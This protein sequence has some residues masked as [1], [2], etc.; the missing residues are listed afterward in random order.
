MKHSEVHAQL[1]DYL[2]GDLPIARRALVDAHI[3]ECPACEVRLS[4]LRATVDLLRSLGDPEPPPGLANAV[5]VRL[6]AGE[7]QPS[8]LATLL[9][10]I[11]RPIRA[12]LA[13]PM[14]V[15]AS[16]AVVFLW[17]RP[18][19]EASPPVVPSLEQDLRRSPLVGSPTAP[20]TPQAA[21]AL[22]AGP[23]VAPEDLDRALRDPASLV[24]AT[25]AL[26]GAQRDAWLAALAQQAGSRERVQALAQALRGLPDPNA[27]A[28]ADAL[29]RVRPGP[30]SR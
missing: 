26:N 18:G 27:A 14:I 12:R 15:L 16:A 22:P 6:A 8:G 29:E 1:G 7:G 9:D 24:Q 2:E 23:A 20:E 3:D 11:P 17:L 4:Q 10:R 19:P 30:Y 28:L 13:T 5:V 21:D 25:A